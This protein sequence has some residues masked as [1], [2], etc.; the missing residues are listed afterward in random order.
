MLSCLILNHAQ[1]S[2]F[3]CSSTI[4]V[5]S[6]WFRIGNPELKK[7]YFLSRKINSLVRQR[8]E[9]RAA[10][11]SKIGAEKRIM[12]KLLPLLYKWHSIKLFDFL[13]TG[14]SLDRWS[15][16][17]HLKFHRFLDRQSI[18]VHCQ[19]IFSVNK[20]KLDCIDIPILFS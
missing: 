3:F 20:F 17:K 2:K 7:T 6:Y 9:T 16:N 13:Q 8:A 19:Q 18:F 5:I 10:A 14:S 11:S 15:V 1:N 12:I 4:L